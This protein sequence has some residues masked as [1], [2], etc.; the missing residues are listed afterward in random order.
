MPISHVKALPLHGVYL[1]LS[2]HR[3]AKRDDLFIYSNFISSLDGRISL[4]DAKMGEF[5]VPSSIAN[6]RDWRLYQELAAQSDVM[7]TSARYFR[8]L[9]QGCAQDLLPV[10]RG[11]A[12]EDL[13]LW[14]HQQGLQPQPDVV[15]VSASLDIPLAAVQMFSDRKVRVITS[16]QS[17]TARRLR[18]EAVGIEVLIAGEKRVSGEALKTCLIALGYRSAYMIAGPQLHHTLLKDQVLNRMFLTTRFSLL[19][20]NDFHTILQGDMPPVDCTLLSLYLD[21]E[22]RQMFAQYAMK[23]A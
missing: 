14:R 11:E 19:G 6:G 2:L 17:D 1:E 3:C 8:Q 10:G 16:N 7:L 21:A 12:Y 9:A 23:Q 20:Q 5:S 4:R 15:I 13:L 22:G 18:L